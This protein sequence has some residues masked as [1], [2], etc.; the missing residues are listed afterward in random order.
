MLRATTISTWWVISSTDSRSS[1]RGV[2]SSRR[3]RHRPRAMSVALP[4]QH[5]QH[6]RRGAFPCFLLG[7]EPPPAGGGQRVIAR[8]AVVVGDAPRPFDE[9]Q[10]L[11]AL[12]RRVQRA[13]RHAEHPAGELLDALADAVAVQR[14]Q[15]ERFEDQQVEFFGSQWR[16]L[17]KS[18]GA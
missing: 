3:R 1:W 13:E 14:R 15:R 10:P 5:A 18:I 11:E 9:S 12:Q 6:G 17:S 8:P 4:V 7:G 16:L 2:I